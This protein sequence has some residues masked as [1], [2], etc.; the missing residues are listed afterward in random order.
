VIRIAAILLAAMALSS[1]GK[2]TDTSADIVI[3]RPDGVV[4]VW[5]KNWWKERFRAPM[6]HGAA[7]T[8][9]AKV[10]Q[11]FHYPA[12]GG[13]PVPIAVDF[14]ADGSDVF[15]AVSWRD[16]S[17]DVRECAETGRVIGGAAFHCSMAGDNFLGQIAR[18]SEDATMDGMVLLLAVGPGGETDCRVDL[19]GLLAGLSPRLEQT[20]FKLAHFPGR[21]SYL[22]QV[23]GEALP[24]YRLQCGQSPQLLGD[25]ALHEA[26]GWTELHDIAPGPDPAQPR[27]ALRTSARYTEAII[28]TPAGELFAAPLDAVRSDSLA[29]LTADAREIITAVDYLFTENAPRLTL[30]LVNIETGARRT[31]DFRHDFE[32][33]QDKP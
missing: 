3:N 14:A 29:F 20:S 12:N 13:P 23:I 22:A 15:P 4:I 5:S 1:C 17:L 21:G 6:D 10:F 32:P 8:L 30:G 24:I 26:G 7:E 18:R 31:L 28:A 25:L 2:R 9:Q 16:E 19:T 27:V 11:A 33:W